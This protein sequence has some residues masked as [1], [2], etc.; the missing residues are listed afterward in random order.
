MPI[1]GEKNSIHFKNGNFSTTRSIIIDL[2]T[3]TNLDFAI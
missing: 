1:I 3:T 2:H